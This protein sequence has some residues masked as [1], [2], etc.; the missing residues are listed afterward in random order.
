MIP[1]LTIRDNT[2]LNNPDGHKQNCSSSERAM[3]SLQS[4]VSIIMPT[5][6]RGPALM[7]AIESI[8]QQDYQ[9]WELLIVGDCC[10]Y[11]QKR[12]PGLR[13]E[14]P[15]PRI[16]WYNLEKNSN[17]SGTTPR[18]FGISKAT[19]E[20]IAYLDDDNTWDPNH[21]SSLVS[22]LEQSNASYVFASFTMN[23]VSNGKR[24]G[25]V[26]PIICRKPLKYRID[27][28]ALLHRKSLIEKY[29]AWSYVDKLS[30]DWEL[31]SRWVNGKE[32]WV[33][34]ELL[35]VNYTADETRVRARLIFN[36][37]GDQKPLS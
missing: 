5:Y 3:Q 18:N 16:Q 24:N 28:S 9:N 6:N 33:A 11:L 32:E 34:T 27:T 29:G 7:L 25:E 12:L 26:Y 20:L 13:Y 15:D 23:V 14:Y 36:A 31:V 37:Y 35:T 4:K 1:F 19:A 10:P 30:H 2:F 8:L 17:N 22:K 21:L